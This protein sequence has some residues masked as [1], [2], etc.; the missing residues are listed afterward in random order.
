MAVVV[1]PISTLSKRWYGEDI[2]RRSG[3]NAKYVVGIKMRA[4]KVTPK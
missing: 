4:K 3:L 2:P 1:L